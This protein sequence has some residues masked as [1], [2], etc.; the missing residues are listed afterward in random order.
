MTEKSIHNAPLA[1]NEALGLLD[2]TFMTGYARLEKKRGTTHTRLAWA[3][4]ELGMHPDVPQEKS[5]EYLEI[6]EEFTRHHSQFPNDGSNNIATTL[7]AALPLFRARRTGYDQTSL[8][9]IRGRLVGVAQQLLRFPS[10][11]TQA[12]HGPIG[13]I[14]FSLAGTR[15]LSSEN[16]ANNAYYPLS[17]REGR[18]Y[19]VYRVQ[20]DTTLP[21]RIDATRLRGNTLK[22]S[23]KSGRFSGTDFSFLNQAQLAL[24]RAN[25]QVPPQRTIN[26]LLAEA[27]GESIDADKQFVLDG[28]SAAIELRRRTPI[29]LRS[30]DK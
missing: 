22:T 19:H 15:Q 3:S 14:G 26:W 7:Y 25:I 1:E 5:E 20:G 28:I 17:R 29:R 18:R 12:G 8:D 2:Q 9:K 13:F 10:T 30:P 11:T 24:E 21:Q 27:K 6:A 16:A 23:E 4:L